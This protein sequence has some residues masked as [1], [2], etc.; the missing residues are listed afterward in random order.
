MKLSGDPEGIQI[1]KDMMQNRIE[2]LKYLITEAKTNFDHSARFK[3]QDGTKKY[4][5]V[6]NPQTGEFEVEQEG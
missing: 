1:L 6:Y 2:Y 4:K 5:L 3:N